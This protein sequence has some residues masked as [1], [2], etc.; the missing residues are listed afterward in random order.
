MY[1][2]GLAMLLLFVVGMLGCGG[3]PVTD[4]P[5]VFPVQGKVTLN[6]EPVVGAD[7]T[8][9]SETANRGAFGRTG[10]D[11]VYKLTTFGNNDGAVEGK[12]SVTIVKTVA[13]AP[14]KSVASVDSADYVPPGYGD[15]PAVE[16]PKALIPARYA[17][18]ET[19]GLIAIV[20][21]DGP[22]QVDFELAE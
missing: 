15:E 21:T 6:G 12:Q 2:S 7:V 1:K 19:S 3:G 4:R 11:G 18:A 22:N 20:N 16:E 5:P 9:V 10:A 8:F 17:S 13:A 14:T